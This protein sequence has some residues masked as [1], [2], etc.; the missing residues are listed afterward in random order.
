MGN[1]IV[2]A[3]LLCRLLLALACVIPT[4]HLV[5]ATILTRGAV[6]ASDYA[7][8]DDAADPDDA[9]YIR[10]NRFASG[11]RFGS[12]RSPRDPHQDRFEAYES[13]LIAPVDPRDERRFASRP[14]PEAIRE[15]T[16]KQDAGKPA[17]SGYPATERRGPVAT[18]DGDYR[19]RFNIYETELISPVGSAEG[20]GGAAY[21]PPVAPQDSPVTMARQTG[22]STDTTPA[23]ETIQAMASPKMADAESQEVREPVSR[24]RLEQADIIPG[25]KSATSDARD[26]T[27]ENRKE[28]DRNEEPE[29]R[30]PDSSG[31]RESR[32]VPEQKTAPMPSVPATQ[33]TS[34]FDDLICGMI[35]VTPDEFDK[36]I[37]TVPFALR[38]VAASVLRGNRTIQVAAYRPEQARADIMTAK[39]VYDPEVFGS[40]SFSRTETPPGISIGGQPQNNTKYQNQLGRAGIRQHTPTGANITAYREWNNGTERNYGSSPEHGHGGAFVVEMS[41]PLL[42]GFADAENRALIDISRLQADITDAEF[43]QTVIETMSKALEAYWVVVQAREEV[44][45]NRESLAMAERLLER[46]LGRKDEGISTQLDV[47]RAREAAATR[48]YNVKLA[49]EQHHQAQENLK[50]LLNDKAVPVGM[51]VFVDPVESFETP[52]V[53]ANLDKSITTALENRPEFENADL[54]VRQSEVRRRFAKHSLL[55]ELNLVG[56]I[57]RNDKDSSTP[58][59]SSS[60]LN[61]GT[62]WTVGMEFAMPIGNMKARSNV[63]KAESEVSQMIEEKKNVRDY[64]ITEVRTVVKNLDLVVREIPLNQRAYDAAVKVLEGEWAKLELNQTGNRDLLQAQDLVAVTDRNYVNSFIRYNVYIVRLFTAEG[65]LLDKMGIR[66]QKSAPSA[67]MGK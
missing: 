54:S 14:K 49:L 22:E 67:D 23:P 42:N 9:Y 51:D 29:K 41:Q 31:P 63:R 64:I 18:H 57:R 20:D 3:P 50:Y 19:E 53:R 46:E 36:P 37:Q 6:H 12:R 34:L 16:S 17:V 13:E 60:T 26:T 38:Q 27:E 52:L 44:R 66:M 45:I 28:E 56:S 55:P 43:R 5:T 2:R 21:R 32:P 33:P 40:L 30:E 48:A 25:K 4:S 1:F 62:D 8:Y 11:G 10:D 61:T 24:V 7:P 65:T 58:T 47:N 59:A 35:A 39:S 15:Q